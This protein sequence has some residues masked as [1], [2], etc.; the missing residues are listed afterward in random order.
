MQRDFYTPSV[1]LY[2]D[3][4]Q[5]VLFMNLKMMN[6]SSKRHS[7]L[8]SL[9]FILKK[10]SRRSNRQDFLTGPYFIMHSPFRFYFRINY[11][12]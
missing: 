2:E 10:K 9:I 7:K 5:N 11:S 8:L 6:D 1:S 12:R 4:L 3:S